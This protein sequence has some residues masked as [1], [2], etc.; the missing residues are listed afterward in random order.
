MNK[1][2]LTNLLHE[3]IVGNKAN[4]LSIAKIIVDN[5][6]SITFECSKDDSYANL[7]CEE[8]GVHWSITKE[9]YDNIKMEVRKLKISTLK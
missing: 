2:N 5:P 3:A 4:A 9:F 1:Q 8:V 7:I 6:N